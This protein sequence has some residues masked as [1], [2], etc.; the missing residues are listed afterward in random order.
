MKNTGTAFKTIVLSSLVLFFSNG[1][2]GSQVPEGLQVPLMRETYEP[3]NC[4]FPHMQ[5]PEVQFM[6]ADEFPVDVDCE[7]DL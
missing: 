3:H 4:D 7:V 1:L 6:A 5:G 2:N